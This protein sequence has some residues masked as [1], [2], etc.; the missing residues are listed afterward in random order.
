MSWPQGLIS[1]SSWR[2]A[3]TAV[4]LA[5]CH[6]M[7]RNHADNYP[8]S[9]PH[10][11]RDNLP[12]LHQMPLW[13]K[14]KSMRIFLYFSMG[15]HSSS[16]KHFRDQE[17]T[18]KVLSTDLLIFEIPLLKIE[19]YKPCFKT[20][21]VCEVNI[22]YISLWIRLPDAFWKI[23]WGTGGKKTWGPCIKHRKEQKG[24]I[25]ALSISIIYFCLDIFLVSVSIWPQIR[26]FFQVLKVF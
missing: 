17:K 18:I 9:C 11:P 2:T 5:S 23:S 22:I 25:L 8:S 20:F 24:D 12:A 13:G 26:T 4:S 7:L 21:S 10:K 19:C 16:E 15:W 3:V 14:R 1:F 6:L